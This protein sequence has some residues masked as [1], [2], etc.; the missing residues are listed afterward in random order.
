VQVATERAQQLVDQFTDNEEERE[1]I[2]LYLSEVP[3]GD[4]Y[5]NLEPADLETGERFEAWLQS[6]GI[7]AF[8][9]TPSPPRRGGDT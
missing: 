2:R 9:E 3:I 6:R 5:E 1:R 8:E 7:A 4:V